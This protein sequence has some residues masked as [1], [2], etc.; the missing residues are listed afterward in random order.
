MVTFTVTL[1]PLTMCNTT[2]RD[3]LLH[4][5][6]S[7]ARTSALRLTCITPFDGPVVP[8]Q[9]PSTFE[10]ITKYFSVSNAL[11]GPMHESHQPG[12]TAVSL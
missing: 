2:H 5:H 7:F 10:Q 4:Q 6:A 1:I 12:F 3:E 8:E 9:P 11:P